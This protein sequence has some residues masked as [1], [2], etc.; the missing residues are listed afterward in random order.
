MSNEEVEEGVIKLGPYVIKFKSRFAGKIITF[1]ILSILF[2][3][4]CYSQLQTCFEFSIL[5]YLTVFAAFIV[6]L[7]FGCS[8][9]DHF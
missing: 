8:T 3:V 2:L 7:I 6:T 1:L 9:S 5:A 4:H